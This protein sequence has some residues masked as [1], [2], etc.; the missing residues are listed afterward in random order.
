MSLV[1]ILLLALAFLQ[2]RPLVHMQRETQEAVV[3]HRKDARH[4]RLWL[5]PAVT[6]GTNGLKHASMSYL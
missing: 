1:L 4:K 3:L 5:L 6:V 2:E